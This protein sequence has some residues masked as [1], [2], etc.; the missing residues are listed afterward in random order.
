MGSSG[1]DG[2]ECEQDTAISAVANSKSSIRLLIAS[3][4]VSQDEVWV[5]A[6]HRAAWR[7]NFNSHRREPVE[8]KLLKVLSAVGA[9]AWRTAAA[10][11]LNISS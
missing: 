9:T 6:K 7:R 3:M 2:A 5:N 11:R 8:N 10:T 4:I 1:A